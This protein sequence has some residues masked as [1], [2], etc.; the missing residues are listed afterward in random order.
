[1]RVYGVPGYWIVIIIE[2]TL[3]LTLDRLVSRMSRVHECD[4]VETIYTLLW[5]KSTDKDISP[6]RCSQLKSLGVS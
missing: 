5:I 2:C 3:N 6:F 4:D 1:M